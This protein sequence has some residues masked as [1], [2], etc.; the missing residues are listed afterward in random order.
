MKNITTTKLVLV[1]ALPWILLIGSMVLWSVGLYTV[2]LFGPENRLLVNIINWTLG[3]FSLLGMAGIPIS[4]IVFLVLLSKRA[5][6]EVTQA[7]KE[8]E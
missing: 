8:Q 3:I 1:L 6:N 7:K 4:L 5:D 2:Q